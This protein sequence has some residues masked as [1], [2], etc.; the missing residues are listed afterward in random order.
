MH[1]GV[2][3]AKLVVE[4]YSTGCCDAKT[5]QQHIGIIDLLLLLIICL[6]LRRFGS[7]QCGGCDQVD[8]SKGWCLTYLGKVVELIL[9][10]GQQHPL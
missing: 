6:G 7:K 1:I 3:A 8:A 9:S 5:I 2:K 4:A 10:K